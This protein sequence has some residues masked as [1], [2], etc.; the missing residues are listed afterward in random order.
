[1]AS[2]SPLRDPDEEGLED[3]LQAEADPEDSNALSVGLAPH[4]RTETRQE[5]VSIF[6]CCFIST[7]CVHTEMYHGHL[8]PLPE[9]SRINQQSTTFA[10]VDE[11]TSASA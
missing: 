9:I 6:S 3:R 5:G 8:G 11:F 7:G 4:P 10:R 2:D 1:M